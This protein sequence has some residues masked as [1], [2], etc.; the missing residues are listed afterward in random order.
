MAETSA[1]RRGELVR[2]LEC[3]HASLS[4]EVFRV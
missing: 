1:H 4:G 2:A 3:Q